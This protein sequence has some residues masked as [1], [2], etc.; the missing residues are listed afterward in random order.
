MC[1]YHVNSSN[2]AKL[3]PA[4]TNCDKAEDDVKSKN[5][6]DYEI[7]QTNIEGVPLAKK[8]DLLDLELVLR[9]RMSRLSVRL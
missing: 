7:F 4:A 8:I 2:L 5:F 3:L 1:E 9:L 6:A